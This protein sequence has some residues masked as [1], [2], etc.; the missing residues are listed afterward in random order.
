MTESS[1][2]AIALS[3]PLPPSVNHLYATVNGRRV[4]SRAGREFKAVVAEAIALWCEQQPGSPPFL[5]L[6]RRRYLALTLVFYFVSPLRRDLDGGLKIA[7]D[8]LCEAIGVND[9]LVVDIHLIKRVDRQNPRLEILLTP[10][11]AEHIDLGVNHNTLPPSAQPTD[12][13]T[14]LS[15]RSKRLKRRRQKARSLEELTARYHWE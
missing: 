4:L 14:Q 15:K 10:M 8:A 2:A 12:E 7:Q 5:E 6:L 3:L 9:N 13:L 1:P 11:A